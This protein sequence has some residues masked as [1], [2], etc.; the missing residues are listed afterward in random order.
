M[1]RSEESVLVAITDTEGIEV[2]VSEGLMLEHI[3]TED[4]RPL[5]EW[6]I[7][8]YFD[9]GRVQAPSREAMLEEW[10][11]Y[12]ADNGIELPDEDVEI[13]TP[14]WAVQLLKANYVQTVAGRFQLEMGREMGAADPQDRVRI[15]AEFADQIG[16]LSLS[17]VPKRVSV[18]VREGL[19]SSLARYEERAANPGVRGMLL[20]LAPIDEHLSGIRPGELGVVAA[21][22]KTGK[23]LMCMYVAK[24]EFERDRCTS[25]F[26]L[27]M[28][29]D[30]TYDR[31]AC[32]A[33]AIDHTRY[34]RGELT[35]DEVEEI[36][37]YVEDVLKSTTHGTLHVIK[38]EPGQRT[39]EAMLRM[40]RMRDTESLIIDQLTFMEHPSEGKKKRDEVIR[41]KM[42]DLKNGL[43]T[44]RNEMSCLL[45]HQINREGVK[46]AKT[47]G[48]LSMEYMADGAEVE[49][50]VDLAFGLYQSQTERTAQMM[51]FQMLAARRLP[52]KD[53]YL[54]WRI[55]KGSIK[56]LR[57]LEQPT[58]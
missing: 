18:E 25:L 9:A 12:I 4:L 41:D 20:G 44:G 29:V 14:R 37:Q 40:A 33:L 36:R 35:A 57:E 5:V 26:T 43:T 45:A 8:W 15:F 32:F 47:T 6:A 58:T 50:T 52:P 2:L 19:A 39:P 13:D 53:W 34:L 54:A 10:G 16:G 24:S 55:S 23:S 56:V 21:G 3:P 30:E 42:H 28:S 17:L 46:A 49:R 27:E 22:A 11:K 48:F 51:K 38:P 31:M 1:N 7:G